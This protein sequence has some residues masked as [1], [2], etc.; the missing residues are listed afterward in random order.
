MANFDIV[1]DYDWTSMPR[2][3]AMRSKAPRVVVKSFKI[4]SNQ[5]L[6]AIQGFISL[7][8]SSGGDGNSYYDKL[9]QES[10]TPDDNFNFPF[11]GDEVRS[12]TNSFGDS[13]QSG[14]GGAG[15]VGTA[16]FEGLKQAAGVVA[17]LSNVT[18]ANAMENAANALIGPQDSMTKLKN[19]GAALAQGGN[20]GTYIETPKFYEF[21]TASDG[22]LQVSFILANTINA[23]SV[24]KNQE[25]IKKLTMINRPNRINSTTVDPPRIYQVRVPGHR[26][27]K[28]AYCSSF[29]VRL[30]GTRRE[31]NGKIV[32]EAYQVDMSFTSMTLEHAGFMEK[33]G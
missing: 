23:D 11:F 19:A 6:Q 33:T 17:E 24:P 27:I 7:G 12:L 16:L 32:P 5:I 13:F 31:I 1:K 4:K 22:P 3:S 30:L 15:G 28:W 14:V 20:P 29:S 8:S 21:N 10:T 9:Y 26:F 25:L 18:S 2:G